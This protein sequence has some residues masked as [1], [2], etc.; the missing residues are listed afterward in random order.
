[1]RNALQRSLPAT[2]VLVLTAHA[3]GQTW[4]GASGD[5][6]EPTNWSG[7][8]IPDLTTEVAIFDTL[9]GYTVNADVAVMIAGVEVANP[10][11]LIQIAPNVVL[12]QVQAATRTNNGTIHLLDQIVNGGTHLAF[13]APITIDGQGKIILGAN[14]TFLS[15]SGTLTNGQDHLIVGKGRITVELINNGTVR[16]DRSAD[17]TNNDSVLS[18]E[19]VPATN[20][21]LIVAVPDSFLDIKATINQSSSGVIRAAGG[22]V[23]HT[24]GGGIAGGLIET[25]IDG[26]FEIFGSTAWLD[27]VTNNGLIAVLGSDLDIRAGGVTNN[28]TISLPAQLV[29]NPQADLNLLDSATIDGTG[30]IRLT[31]SGNSARIRSSLPATFTNGPAHTIR[32]GGVIGMA[33]SNQ[34]AVIAD[35]TVMA[36]GETPI[37]SL[38]DDTANTGTLAAAA[39]S[40]FRATAITIDQSGGG[41]II[42][43]DGGEVLLSNTEVIGGS[44]SAIGSGRYLFTQTNNTF[45]DVTT[46]GQGIVPGNQRLQITG[47]GLTNNGVLSLT[48]TNSAVTAHLRFEDSGTL[49]GAGALAMD[50]AFASKSVLSVTQPGA[51]ITNGPD[52]TIVSGIGWINAELVNEGTLRLGPPTGRTTISQ[53]FLCAPSSRMIF[54]IAGTAA[55]DYDHTTG[56]ADYTLAGGLTVELLPA[57]TPTAGDVFALIRGALRTG[58]F[59]TLDLPVGNG[60][61]VWKIGYRAAGVDLVYTCPADIS[62]SANPASDDF[63]I[64]DGTLGAEDFFY[65]LDR[66]AAGD[67]T[68]ADLTG[69]IDPNSPDFGVPDHTLGAEDFFF[70]L[71]LFGQGCQ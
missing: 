68:V 67:L 65:Y 47:S 45:E 49:A 40:T 57:Y 53:P 37:L 1:M 48:S 50:S 12:T 22:I 71:D 42:A 54:E 59:D 35:G 46:A 33:L 43:Q 61:L 6:S 20:N 3:A 21:A 70:Y 13:D 36:P 64:P 19:G 16:A 31:Q 2:L 27:G 30:E 9:V 32:G 55:A 23:R 29:G 58:H 10:N 5:W 18:F 60:F 17:L 44:V 51:V 66:F 14:T 52:H 62:G 38:E 7:G 34:G 24:N 63:G 4:I 69:S 39:G 8:N 15:G 25:S 26:V 11:A 41:A 28:G 56:T